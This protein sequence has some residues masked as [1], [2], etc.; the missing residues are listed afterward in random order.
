MHGCVQKIIVFLYASLNCAAGYANSC[1]D[2]TA[3][4]YYAGNVPEIADPDFIENAQLFDM[5]PPNKSGHEGFPDFD[6]YYDWLTNSQYGP[7][8]LRLN[9]PVQKGEEILFHYDYNATSLGNPLQSPTSSQLP[10]T[11]IFEELDTGMVEHSDNSEGHAESDGGEEEE[12]EEEEEA[13]KSEGQAPSEVSDEEEKEYVEEATGPFTNQ[14]QVR[15]TRPCVD[16]NRVVQQ[17]C[18]CDVCGG[19]LHAFN[20]LAKP[21]TETEDALHKSRTCNDCLSGK[22]ASQQKR[23]PRATAQ[24]YGQA[25][26]LNQ[27]RLA[28]GQLL[29]LPKQVVL[30]KDRRNERLYLLPKNYSKE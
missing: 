22:A 27:N 20:C 4:S 24:L 21:G 17:D 25:G 30:I 19:W 8:A 29:N 1:K 28:E 6:A 12:E 16:C 15:E 13:E 7:I 3:E 10:K 11:P 9:R 5:P 23:T 26:G 14:A 2:V 18:V